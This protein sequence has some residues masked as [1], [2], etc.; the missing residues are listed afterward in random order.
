MLAARG[1]EEDRLAKT[2]RVDCEHL[3]LISNTLKC[4]KQCG[5]LPTYYLPTYLPT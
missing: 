4:D 3:S 1:A 2:C 5:Y